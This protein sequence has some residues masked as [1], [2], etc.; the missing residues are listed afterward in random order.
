M[1]ERRGFPVSVVQVKRWEWLR[2]A[3]GLLD[4]AFWRGEQRPDGLACKAITFFACSCSSLLHSSATIPLITLLTN[5]PQVP[6]ADFLRCADGWYLERT[7]KTIDEVSAANEGRRV[8]LIAHSAGGW[9]ARAALA[10]GAWVREGEQ[11][12]SFVRALVTLGSPHFPPPAG[13]SA[14]CATRG[15]LA[16][17]DNAYPG[18][19][20]AESQSIVYLTV[21]GSAIQAIDQ[22]RC[23]PFM[24]RHS[25]PV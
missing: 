11:A 15:A 4:A 5:P 8:L 17:T 6:R 13:A 16:F 18:A 22:V 3:G 14:S 9:L 21:A 12:G 24:P 19:H 2:V 10:D 23:V 25:L 7:L 20:L 1:L